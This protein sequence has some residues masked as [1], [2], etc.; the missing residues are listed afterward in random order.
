[1]A[2]FTPVFGSIGRAADSQINQ[3][4]AQRNQQV[5]KRFLDAESRKLASGE[6]TYQDFISTAAAHGIAKVPEVQQ[7]G[8]L[9]KDAEEKRIAKAKEAATQAGVKSTIQNIQGEPI[10]GVGDSRPPE[11]DTAFK[12]YYKSK[13]TP[14]NV[15]PSGFTEES[16]SPNQAGMEI[17]KQSPDVIKAIG[18]T[19]FM[20]AYG[21]QYSAEQAALD[22]EIADTQAELG[23]VEIA[24]A[25]ENAQKNKQP[26]R[27]QFIQGA[28]NTDSYQKGIVPKGTIEE[29]G[30][31]FLSAKDYSDMRE[32][33]RVAADRLDGKARD[34]FVKNSDSLLRQVNFYTGE[35]GRTQDRMQK[36][37]TERAKTEAEIAALDSTDKDDLNKI[38]VFENR[39]SALDKSLATLNDK[40]YEFEGKRDEFL[41]SHDKLTD[42]SRNVS[43]KQ[44]S[45]EGKSVRRPD[46]EP[47][48]VTPG[49]IPEYSGPPQFLKRPEPQQTPLKP[50]KTEA[51]IRADLSKARNKSGEPLTQAQIETVIAESKR[52]GLVQ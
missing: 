34:E 31:Q 4:R 20:D 16:M 33:A 6:S 52:R 17:A 22:K 9:V 18:S 43:I 39:I 51:Q 14:Q 36:I 44:A 27:E 25:A 19:G 23:R 21:K 10:M 12:E 3:Q 46:Y 15:Q 37:E 40:M 41:K 45:E 30:S 50:K 2:T 49:S 7:Y 1:M 38:K 29:I 5:V 11:D 24:I 47:N 26:T 42:L 48:S 32:K 13:Y 8:L 35:I 28:T